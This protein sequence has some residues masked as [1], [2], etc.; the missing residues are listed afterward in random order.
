MQ[1]AL[2]DQVV[3]GAGPAAPGFPAPADAIKADER[4]QKNLTHWLKT[5]RLRHHP[6]PP[7]SSIK[8]FADAFT[9]AAQAPHVQAWFKSKG[10]DLSTVRVFSD[11][12]E[13]MVEVDGKQQAQKFTATDGSGWGGVSAQVSNAVNKLSADAEG[14]LLP[15]ENGEFRH[16]D[17]ILG[18]YGV[19]PP[20]DPKDGPQL[21]K[22]LEKD[23]WPTIPDEKRVAWRRQYG[24]LVG[25]NAD[26]AQ[27]NNLL[28]WLAT[29]TAPNKPLPNDAAITPFI[30]M[31]K[32]AINEPAL[33]A[34]IKSAGLTPS[35]VQIFSDS[36]VGTV[37]RDGKQT[38][39]RFSTTDGSGWGLVS[40]RVSALQKILSPNDLGMSIDIGTTPQV[41]SRNVQ[42]DFYGVR[43]PR[44]EQ[45]APQLGARLKR[46]GWP[47][48]SQA[49]RSE[50]AEQSKRQKQVRDDNAVRASLSFQ[51]QPLLEGKQE[52]DTLELDKLIVV[53]G[54]ASTLAQRSKQPRE[55]LL[56]F[57][58]SPAFKA[59]LD[60]AGLEVP[61][62]AKYRLS[63]GELQ[64][65]NGAAQ[66]VSLQRYFDDE[67][68]KVSAAGSAEQ[69]QAARKMKSEFDQLVVLSNE[70]G[71]AL[72][73]TPI[74]DARQ[75][76]K[77]YALDVP[78][79]AGKLRATLELLGNQFPPPPLAGNYA[80]MTP[81]GQA[82]GAL[83]AQAEAKLKGFSTQ[84]MA[85]FKDFSPAPSGVQSYPDPDRQLAA[86]FDSPKAIMLAEKIAKALKLFA[87]ADG[88]ALPRAERYQL[89]ATALKLS[90]NGPL[91]GLPGTVAGYEVYQP[92]NLG[93]TLKEVRADVEKH[94]ESKRVDPKVSALM[95]HLYLA[96]SAPEMLIKI[97]PAVAADTHPLLNQNPENIKV[98]S[99]GWMNMRVACAMASDSRLEFK[100]AMA[101]VRLD[102]PGPNQEMLIKSMGRQPLLDWGAMSG[103]YPA[104]R[105]RQ[106]SEENYQAAS[107]AFIQRETQTR[108]ALDTLMREPPTQTSLLVKQLA[109]LFP[110]MTEEEIRNIKLAGHPDLGNA[111]G[112]HIAGPY[113]HT[114]KLLTDVI[115][116]NQAERLPLL[117][118]EDS[119]TLGVTIHPNVPL[120][121][122][123]E[124]LKQLPMIEPLVAP[125]V[126]KYIADTRAAHATTLKLMFAQLPLKQRTELESS[127][128][129]QF[130]TLRKETGDDIEADKRQASTI[131]KSKG[132]QGLLMRFK[133]R[134]LGPRYEFYEVFPNSMTMV[135]RPDLPNNL[136][137]GGTITEVFEPYGR[138]VESKGKFH[139]GTTLPFDFE[140]YSSGGAP[141]PDAKSQLILEQHGEPLQGT[142]NDPGH[143]PDTFASS[144]VSAVVEKLLAHSFDGNR[145][146]RIAHANQP[147]ALHRAVFPN[148]PQIFS[149]ENGRLVLGLIPFVGA[150]A[151]LVEGKIAS[152]LQGLVID[153][154]SFLATGGLAGLKTVGTG[155]KM[156]I[157]FSRKPFTMAG[158]KAGGAFVRGLLNPLENIPSILSAGPKLVNGAK[159]VI[160]GQPVK[161]GGDIYM[162]VKMYEQWRWSVGAE[163]AF[164][165]GPG[166]T[167]GQWPGA[168][169]G[170]SA[171]GEVDAIQKNGS[172]Y[173]INPMSH[174]PEG[175]PL[176]QYT[177]TL[178]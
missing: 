24:Q 81:Y 80:G 96:Q 117:G 75:A 62:R 35:S 48:K 54:P 28:Q 102:A 170:F 94:L 173:E 100:Q 44:T 46:D 135:H 154:A 162:P 18:F 157:P 65:R 87:V 111:A 152:G 110:E 116:L 123:K 166:G 37:L 47:K 10:L 163:S 93:R 36:V 5:G 156:L 103:L 164:A 132:A 43:Q 61:A 13:G 168:R 34:W 155:L 129:I 31:Y 149:A 142:A 6:I 138:F 91:P 139:Q 1:Q 92:G 175:A 107:Q 82:P 167:A 89:L 124:R 161:L 63:E 108:E 99:T 26:I 172:W 56:Q 39:M 71:N 137:V 84:A 104:T 8:P 118:R 74:Y 127:G 2:L 119:W 68:E 158:L 109:L 42:L 79:T 32:A 105:D 136:K 64:Q 133:M 113:E 45:A 128:E 4:L 174:R 73:S 29:G 134:E 90:V 25:A 126:D 60:K 106:Y 122:F 23:G 153:V 148:T 83:P 112:P 38:S 70:T 130:Y 69:Q 144:T 78:Q 27:Q 140:A 51:L 76:L 41:I 97:D 19:T 165:A 125:A 40:A 52:D 57:L 3:V 88:Q 146:A 49:Q 7:N 17:V 86:F 143:I 178:S 159:K 150:I 101:L 151:D 58:G 72:Y 59:F 21:G 115:L 9:E 114:P 53:V 147:T 33:R 30:M 12:V 16:V 160:T 15:D 131:E 85:L 121:T 66:W 169:K 141:R 55:R 98:G 22:Q 177:P 50:W 14:V 67:V 11:R 95:A 171:N 176:E 120:E 145:D 20:G 77:H